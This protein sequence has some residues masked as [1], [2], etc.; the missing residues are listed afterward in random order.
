MKAA[1]ATITVR[2]ADDRLR[3]QIVDAVLRVR[4]LGRRAPCAHV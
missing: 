4:P 2:F 3:R 1:R